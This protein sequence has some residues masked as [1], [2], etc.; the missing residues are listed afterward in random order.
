MYKVIVAD[1]EPTALSHI[2]TIIELKCPNFEVIAT[3]DNGESALQK[4]R[5]LHPDI[6]ISDIKMPIMD[7]ITLI[8]KVKEEI[9]DTLSIIVSGY[10]DFEYA[11]G[12]IRSGVCDYLLKPVKPSSLKDIL[13]QLELKLMTFHYER[14]NRMIRNLCTGCCIPGQ[15]ELE[16]VF[17]DR[18]Y[19]MAIMRKNGIPARFSSRMGIE[20]FSIQDEKMFVYGRDEME[21]LY[22]CPQKLLYRTNFKDMILKTIGKSAD[23]T[24]FITAVIREEPLT[25]GEFPTVIKEL[26]RKMDKSIIIGKN[27]TIMLD[28]QHCQDCSKGFEENHFECIEYAIQ[29]KDSHKVKK[30]IQNLL[31]KWE[32]EKR[33]QLWVEGKIRYIFCVM[34]KYSF[35]QETQESSEFMLDDAF[36]YA[37]SMDNL[38]ESILGIICQN[39]NEK[40]RMQSG[41]KADIYRDITE[42]LT[43]HICDELSIQL[44]CKKFGISQTSLSKLFRT[45]AD[46]SFNNYLTNIRIE[47]AKK[48]IQQDPDV[49]VKDVANRVGYC[50]QFYF[51]RI[52]HSVAGVCPSDYIEQLKSC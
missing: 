17:S 33:S 1:D 44:V 41:D 38:C 12:A 37:A 15:E 50:D 9:P 16:E 45:Y 10:Q 4:V 42:Y 27:Q 6:L 25:P 2:C 13:D 20:I 19:Y 28:N 8:S 3:A 7:G 18:Y 22:I 40:V 47:K 31:K 35:L 34:H 23:N 30:E 21:S 36:S 48:I 24:S 43:R 52:F 29:Q 14:R 11:K 26:Y 51:S 39:I 32:T 49:F 5:E 46:C